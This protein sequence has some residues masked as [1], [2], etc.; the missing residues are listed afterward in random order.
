[1]RGKFTR[2][3]PQESKSQISSHSET[4]PR[5]GQ[6][7]LTETI[8]EK[9]RVKCDVVLYYYALLLLMCVYLVITIKNRQAH[10][11]GKQSY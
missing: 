3:N 10:R 1:M 2:V 9:K 6:V 8:M 4:E 5:D 7:V 11:W